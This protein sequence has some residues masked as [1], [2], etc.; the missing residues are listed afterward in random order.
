MLILS[1]I[2]ALMVGITLGLLGSGGSIL[3]LPLLVYLLGREGDIAIAESLAIVGGIAA[4]GVI[5]HARKGLVEWRTAIIFGLPSMAGAYGGAF[6]GGWMNDTL[7]LIIFACVML[8]AAV[9][10]FRKSRSKAGQQDDAS[11]RRPSPVLIAI[12]GLVVGVMTGVVGVGGG[13]LI[14]P[15]LVLLGR[16]PIHRAVATSLLIITANS[17]V[18][19][20]RY[21][22]DL[23]AD[24]LHIDW[25]IIGLFVVIGAGGTFVGKAVGERISQASLRKAFAVFLVIM[26]VVIIA[27]ESTKLLAAPDAKAASTT[28]TAD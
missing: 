12:Q 6:I 4:V 19:F 20:I 13:F 24:D 25:R 7:Q 14:V 27:R 8:T 26:G 10:M 9:F 17:V 18:A 11:S 16:L 28:E 22:I 15:A 2:G 3:T 23:A 21:S 1:L 5:P